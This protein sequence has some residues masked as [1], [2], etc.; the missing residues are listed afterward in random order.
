[1]YV[2]KVLPEKLNNKRID[3][4]L[5]ELDLVSSRQ[6]AISMI[7]AGNVFV[8]E[9]KIVKPGKTVKRDSLIK[10]RKKGHEWVSRGGVKLSGAIKK[11]KV[12][13][14]NK[15]CLDI[16]CSTG[17]F[18][19]VLLESGAKIIY[20]VDVGYGQFDWG[21]RNSK[22]IILLE[23]TN[24]RHL[25]FSLIPTN[26]DLVVC[27]VSFISLKK[28]IQPIK[29]LLKSKFE[30]VALIK[31]Q[32]EVNKKLV[33][34]GGIIKD[35]LIHQ[36]VCESIRSWFEYEFKTDFIQLMTS[37]IEGQKGNKEFFIYVKK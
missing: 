1:M 11:F 16:G 4:I 23:K 31:P 27:D 33:G 28:V 13:V 32:F 5:V 12:D 2:S 14:R 3:S 17:G 25:N 20:A 26:L 22:K 34:R 8:N 18:S 19:D 36:K 29:Q 15:I 37:P 24:A 30:I 6:K 21:L 9:S 7:M 35:T 10:I